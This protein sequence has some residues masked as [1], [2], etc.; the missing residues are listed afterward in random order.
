MPKIESRWPN[1]RE[2]WYKSLTLIN[3]A[4]LAEEKQ[5]QQDIVCLMHRSPESIDLTELVRL[6]PERQRGVLKYWCLANKNVELGWNQLHQIVSE[7]V[8]C[9]N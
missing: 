2:S 9:S 1:Y 6:S 8:A 5:A 4:C 7:F 3:E